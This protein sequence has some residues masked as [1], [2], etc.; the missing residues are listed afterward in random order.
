MIVKNDYNVLNIID[1]LEAVDI[2]QSKFNKE[3]LGASILN[4]KAQIYFPAGSTDKIEKKLVNICS[5]LNVKWEWSKQQHEDWHL[6]WQNNFKPFHIDEKLAIVPDWDT[7]IDS[8]IKIIIKP[9]MAFGTGHH[10]TTQ[11]I[12]TEMLEYIQPGMRVLDMGAGSGILSIAAYKL[13]ALHID[14]I[15]NDLDCKENFFKNLSL[16]NISN[17]IYLLNQD[18]LSYSM[19]GYDVVLIN[20]NYNVI[21]KLISKLQYNKSIYIITGLLVS[22]YDAINKLCSKNGIT[23]KKKNIKGEWL[24][25]II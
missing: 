6:L 4:G 11:L 16:N 1:D 15:E 8:E 9:G 24:C 5:N 17:N 25:L 23:I 3:C 14:A 7:E 21:K 18:V 20:I 22:D 13:D 10:E 2:I 19:G 12:L